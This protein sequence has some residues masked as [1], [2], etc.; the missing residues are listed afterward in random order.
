MSQ[1]I[2]SSLYFSDIFFSQ[3]NHF[4]ELQD[5]DEEQY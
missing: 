1:F 3:R 2:L 5:G 4:N